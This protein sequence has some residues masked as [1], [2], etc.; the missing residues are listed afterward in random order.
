MTAVDIRDFLPLLIGQNL[1]QGDLR[2]HHDLHLLHFQTPDQLG[3]LMHFRFVQDPGMHQPVQFHMRDHEIRP[4]P[5]ALLLPIETQAH[6]LLYLVRRQAQFF[7]E[8]QDM[9]ERVVLVPL[10][11][12]PRTV[13]GIAVAAAMTVFF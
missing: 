13:S 3:H 1:E 9:T 12:M 10:V 7:T 11:T 4:K 5:D 8:L 2:L 6:D